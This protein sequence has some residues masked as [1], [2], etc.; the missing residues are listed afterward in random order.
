MN[1]NGINI[2][3]C[4]FCISHTVLSFHRQHLIQSPQ[5]QDRVPE[6]LTK[7]L[8]VTELITDKAEIY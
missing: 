6:K 3:Q 7:L 5:L 4:D 2:H 1:N 8:M